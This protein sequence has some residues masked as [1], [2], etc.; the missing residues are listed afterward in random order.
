MISHTGH[1]WYERRAHDS[2]AAGLSRQLHTSI[3]SRVG[4]CPVALTISPAIL[5]EAAL[6]S[7]EKLHTTGTRSSLIMEVLLVVAPSSD[8][9]PGFDLQ[10]RDGEPCGLL[11]NSMAVG[12]V[13]PGHG[14]THSLVFM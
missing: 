12:R 5:D 10:R 14:R 8:S 3:S 13:I 11:Q 7:F 9:E 6:A 1:L 2:A 4:L